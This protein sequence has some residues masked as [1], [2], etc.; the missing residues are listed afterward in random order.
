MPVALICAREVLTS[1]LGRLLAMLAFADGR[2]ELWQPHYSLDAGWIVQV[3]LY[4]VR[5]LLDLL[6]LV[7]LDEQAVDER[8]C[9]AEMEKV[10]RF[11]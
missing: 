8:T 6:H 1:A 5:S 2:N 3:A 10:R 9:P 7:R 11:E 4:A